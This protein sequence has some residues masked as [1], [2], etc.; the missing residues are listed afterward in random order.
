MSRLLGHDRHPLG[1][2]EQGGR[3]LRVDRQRLR[4]KRRHR[5]RASQDP[6]DILQRRGG[7]QPRDGAAQALRPL[8]GQGRQGGH[9]E[10]VESPRTWR[11]A[12]VLS[13][14]PLALHTALDV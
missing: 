7:N 10:D 8:R 12:R 4:V 1:Q 5:G 13:T 2:G 9:S 14:T 3:S 6:A 11:A